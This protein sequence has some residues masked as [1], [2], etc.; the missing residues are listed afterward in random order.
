MAG[1]PPTVCSFQ[2]SAE[3][4]FELIVEIFISRC[5]FGGSLKPLSRRQSPRGLRLY[6]KYAANFSPITSFLAVSPATT[7]LLWMI[8]EKRS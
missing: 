4:S 7:I 6:A 5:C 1:Q 2:L 8:R 3:L